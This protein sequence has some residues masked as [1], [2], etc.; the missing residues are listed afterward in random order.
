MDI[1]TFSTTSLRSLISLVEKRDKLKARLAEVEAAISAKIGGSS[2]IARIPG[3]GVVP[4]EK[5]TK[6]GPKAKVGKKKGKHGA[7]KEL[8]VAELKAAGKS[9]ASVRDL[10]AKLGVKPQNVHVWFA[11][12]GK[13]VGV[14]K[15]SPGTYSL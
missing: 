10:A 3:D 13:T 15:I 8:I 1:S 14:K 6:R 4:W 12:T 5:S 11:T 9:G 2:V 7:L